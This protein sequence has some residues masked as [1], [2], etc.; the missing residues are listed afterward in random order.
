MEHERSTQLKPAVC[1]FAEGREEGDGGGACP[2]NDP[3]KF[4]SFFVTENVRTYCFFRLLRRLRNVC[5]YRLNSGFDDRE[6]VVVVAAVVLGGRG[7]GCITL[8]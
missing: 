6:T 8:I 2:R 1:G 5:F 3:L 4:F 7:G